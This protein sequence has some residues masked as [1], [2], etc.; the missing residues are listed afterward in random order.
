MVA[1]VEKAQFPAQHSISAVD[2][3]EED[4]K[5]MILL[6]VFN[7]HTYKLWNRPRVIVS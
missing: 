1:G 2:K 5:Y 6:C 4:R 7:V 3:E